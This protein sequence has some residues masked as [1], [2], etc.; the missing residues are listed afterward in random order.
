MRHVWQHCWH[1][2]WHESSY[3]SDTSNEKNDL[4]FLSKLFS[5]N[6]FHV[7]INN[8]YLP[9][10][11]VFSPS[12][13]HLAKGKPIEEEY[14]IL[15]CVVLLIRFSSHEAK[16]LE[17]GEKGNWFQEVASYVNWVKHMIDLLKSYTSWSKHIRCLAKLCTLSLKKSCHLLHLCFSASLYF[18]YATSHY[19]SN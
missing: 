6:Y 19:C 8:V 11:T 15:I 14:R 3:A 10:W 1:E 18:L 2:E 4:N 13:W 5:N 12:S 7:W 16:N 9:T 17:C